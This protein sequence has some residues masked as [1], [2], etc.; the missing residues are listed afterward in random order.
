MERLRMREAAAKARVSAQEVA[1]HG[2]ATWEPEPVEAVPGGD[3]L[4]VLGVG[5]SEPG[6]TA[7]TQATVKA[8]EAERS[9]RNAGRA[10]VKESR[11]VVE[12]L[13]E[14]GKEAA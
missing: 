12:A 4:E 6:S 8:T 2:D 5:G 1:S 7:M 14:A 10:D 11:E 9:V 3:R 13:P